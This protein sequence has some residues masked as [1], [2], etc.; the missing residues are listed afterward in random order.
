MDLKQLKTFVTLSKIKNYTKTASE[1]DYAQSSISAQIKHLEQ[2]LNTK[3]FDRIGKNVSLT[4]SGERLLPYATE[5]LSISTNAKNQMENIQTQ[6]GHLI[7]GVSESLCIS[8]LPGI[9]KTF[10]DSH[11]GIELEMKL[12]QNEQSLSLLADNS[13]D[14]AMLIGNPIEHP[15]I[16]TFLK[17]PESI[18]ILAY[19]GHPLCSQNQLVAKNFSGHSFILTSP[20]CNYRTAFEYDLRSKGICYRVVLETSSIQTIKEMAMSKLGPCILP[21]IATEKELASGLLQALPYPNNYPIYTQLFCH[22]AKW[23]SPALEDFIQLCK[24][25][26][27]P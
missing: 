5:I 17:R 1:L 14:I 7:I 15:S 19:P 4:T 23:V 18:L 2:E 9:V 25:K 12:I 21:R 27:L 10:L 26:L 20:G 13:I 6:Q 11:P 16:H 22:H 3:L 24:I 8:V